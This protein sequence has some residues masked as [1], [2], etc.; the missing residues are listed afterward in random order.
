LR[1]TAKIFTNGGSLAVRLPAEFRLAGS[2][3]FIRKDPETGEVILTEKPQTWDG[4]LAALEGIDVPED[5]LD[6]E[7]RKRMVADPDP[8]ADM[9]E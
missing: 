2:E 9:D 8:F 7:E 4:F 1:Q 3:V 5:I 6:L